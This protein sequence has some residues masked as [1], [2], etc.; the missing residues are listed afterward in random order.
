M[1]T[2]FQ[3]L[4]LSVTFFLDEKSNQ[5]NQEN[6]IP[7]TGYAPNSD[8]QAGARSFTTAIR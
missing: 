5:K 2:A 8:F 4:F 3:F 7:R 1:K 6:L